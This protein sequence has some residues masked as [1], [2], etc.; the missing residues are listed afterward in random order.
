ML[1]SY[2][3]VWEYKAAGINYLLH[4][5]GKIIPNDVQSE[6]NSGPLVSSLAKSP[7]KLLATMRSDTI[8]PTQVI[9]ATNS[10]CNK[11]YNHSI[12]ERTLVVR[13]RKHIF[14]M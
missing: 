1:L 2:H 11:R 8:L 14:P 7:H 5:V 6:P 12:N 13:K 10:I 4:I 9:S 3:C